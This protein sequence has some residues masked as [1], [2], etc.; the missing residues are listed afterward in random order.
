MI[1]IWQEIAKQAKREA[2]HYKTV[3]YTDKWLIASLLIV[4]S[5]K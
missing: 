2:I 3:L 1:S 5:G 4:E